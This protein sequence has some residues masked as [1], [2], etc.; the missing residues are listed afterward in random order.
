MRGASEK[1]GPHRKTGAGPGS[2][3]VLD[4]FGI[5]EL[6]EAAVNLL[7]CVDDVAQIAA[8]SDAALSGIPV[9]LAAIKAVVER[10]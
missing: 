3:G 9:T 2:L 1:C 5:G 6:L 8:R 10:G 7:V 4:A